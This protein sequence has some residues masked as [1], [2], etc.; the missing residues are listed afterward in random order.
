MHA[1][2]DVLQ[3][4]S[5]IAATRRNQISSEQTLPA[6]LRTVARHQAIDYL[7]RQPRNVMLLDAQ[8]LDRVEQAFGA[9]DIHTFSDLTDAL[10]SCVRGLSPYSQRLV[11]LRYSQ[12]LSGAR[13]AESVHRRTDAVT[14]ALTRIHRSL[15]EC[16][17]KRL[18]TEV[19]QHG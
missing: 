12:G 2:E 5:M 13:L 16:V 8:T 11:H 3:N 18:A 6:W 15:A 1:A 17:R 14:R 10:R 4:V 9:Y 19:E 7:R